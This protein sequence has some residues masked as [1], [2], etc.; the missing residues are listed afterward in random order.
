[1]KK[2]SFSFRAV[3]AGS[4]LY[5]FFLG[6]M[7]RRRLRNVA[8]GAAAAFTINT[9]SAQ[10]DVFKNA[11]AANPLLSVLDKTKNIGGFAFADI[12]G[13]GDQDVYI[14]YNED[15]SSVYTRLHLFRNIGTKEHPVFKE[16]TETGFGRLRA[17]SENGEMQ[18]VDIDGDGDLDYFASENGDYY[19]VASIFS[20]ENVGTSKKPV[21]IPS[22]SNYLPPTGNRFIQPFAFADI[23]GDGDYDFYEAD[24]GFYLPDAYNQRVYFNVGTAKQ[25]IFDDNYYVSNQD[26]GA[27]YRTY[28][29]WN[30][31]GLLDYFDVDN[32]FGY[33]YYY[34]NIGPKANPAYKLDYANGPR[35]ANNSLLPYRIIDLNNDGA[36]EVF[37]FDAH[38]SVLT[39]VGVIEDT[40]ITKGNRQY[41]ILRSKNGGRG[42]SFRWEYNG[43]MIAG[44]DKSVILPTQP[45]IYTLYVTNECGTGVSLNY[46]MKKPNTQPFADSKTAS[47]TS[48]NGIAARAYPNPFTN[49]IT[50]Q[51]PG[52]ACTI[53]V[54]DIAGRVLISQNTSAT[55]LLLGERLKAGTYIIEVWMD[56]KRV[57]QTTAVKQ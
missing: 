37:D 53:R 6:K 9:A 4:Y 30:K 51:L 31:D 47:F 26:N 27:L 29:D 8:V 40:V 55:T 28:Y 44:A 32:R 24:A 11:D 36:P 19:K 7:N 5:H 52:S 14:N 16:D 1:M 41:T 50:L 20:Y 12:D 23:D 13:D 18:F 56:K 46:E 2:A 39:P 48:V 45:G 38:Y 3:R 22:S 15:F 42:Y 10:C 25:P 57:Y 33:Y 43:K 49:A 35:F 54:T 21:F 17:G 34:K